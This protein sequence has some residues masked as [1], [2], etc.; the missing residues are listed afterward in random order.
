HLLFMH[1]RNAFR[2]TPAEREQ[3]RTFLNRGGTLFANAICG[4]QAFTDAFRQEMAQIFPKTPLERV[5]PNDPVWTPSFGGF[6]L[7]TVS[8]RDPQPT[9]PG[10]KLQAVIRQGPPSFEGIKIDGRWVVLFS[11]YD[12]SCALEKH[13]S[14]ECR[15]YSRDDAARIAINVVLY[16]LQQ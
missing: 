14:L 1:G 3:L 16:A 4:S 5:P 8:R 12:L 9:A 2:F 15:G 6:D 7:K 10:G 13:D 11:P